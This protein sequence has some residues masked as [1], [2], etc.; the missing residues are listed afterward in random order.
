MARKKTSL[1][2]DKVGGTIVIQRRLLGSPAYL[3]LSLHARCL[4]PLLQCHW[5]NDKPVDFSTRMAASLL[6]CDR[7][8]A[9]RAFDELAAAGFVKTDGISLFNSRTGSK[10]RSWILTWLP[11][12]SRPPTNDW[13]RNSIFNRYTRR[14]T[15]LICGTPD[16]P[17]IFGELICGTP[18]APQIGVFDGFV[19]HQMHHTYYSHRYGFHFSQNIYHLVQEVHFPRNLFVRIAFGMRSHSGRIF[20]ACGLGNWD[21]AVTLHSRFK[22]N[23]PVCKL[24]GSPIWILH[25]NWTGG[26]S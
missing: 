12:M 24:L 7:R 1:P 9:M 8:L 3:R 2:F 10:A 17:Q 16:A 6:S 20:P 14:T 23:P 25:P 21:V 13:E 11:Y 15:K 26:R 18:D 19:V 22:K 4:M 5:R